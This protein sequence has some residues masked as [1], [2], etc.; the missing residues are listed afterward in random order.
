VSYDKRMLDVAHS[1]DPWLAAPQ[2]NIL[3][4]VLDAGASDDL[5]FALVRALHFESARQVAYELLAAADRPDA[6][7]S[8]V[9]ALQARLRAAGV[10]SRTG[11]YDDAIAILR[12]IQ[13]SEPVC[14]YFGQI[15]LACGFAEVGEAAE[16]EALA[17]SVIEQGTMSGLEEFVARTALAQNLAFSGHFDRALRWVDE[18]IAGARTE[19][20]LVRQRMVKL[21]GACKDQVLGFQRD[22]A[23][24]GV[25][26]P[27]MMRAQRQRRAERAVACQI[28]GPPWPT[29][30]EGC[31]L[32]WPATEYHRL[33]RQLPGR[34]EVIGTPWRGHTARVESALT[35]TAAV[36][37]KSLVAAD[38]IQFVRF[39]EQSG[40]DPLAASTMASFAK[41]MAGS[42]P[43]DPWPPGRRRCWC[44]SG[45]RYPDCCAVLRPDV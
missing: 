33:I 28:D 41:S 23:A 3:G 25:Y 22:A 24:D 8:D 5:E 34:G 43:R 9:T 17:R 13:A 15:G 14:D 19:P 16:A 45:K 26:D 39:L 31:L 37:S 4:F 12:E 36:E 10:L 44:R 38:F 18:A 7:L 20:G 35:M 11:N 40:A 21:A 1:I 42:Q 32:W 2:Q 30:V 29:T 27:D 6:S